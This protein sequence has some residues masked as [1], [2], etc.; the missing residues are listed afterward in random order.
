MSCAKKLLFVLALFFFAASA[1]AQVSP[2][3]TP[4]R[5]SVTAKL[6]QMSGHLI[7]AC[8]VKD[9]SGLAVPS[10]IVSVQKAAAITGPYAIW[11]SKITNVKGQALFP[12]AQP[13]YTWYVRCAATA[14]TAAKQPILSVSQTLTIKGKKPRPSPTATSRP[15]ATATPT[16]RPTVTPS[17]TPRPTVT[18]SPT[19]R[20]TATPTVTLRPTV[21]PTP[22]PRPTATPKPTPP[23]P[24]RSFYVAPGGSNSADG[25]A[26]HPWATIQHAADAVAAG[27]T[28][29][30]AAGQYN[31]TSS[32]TTN[33][34]G[35]ANAPIKFISDTPW[36]SKIYGT[37]VNNYLWFNNGDYN[38]VQGFEITGD[39]N[40]MG[41]IYNYA[42]YCLYQGN[43]VHDILANN[44]GGNGGSGLD[45]GGYTSSYNSYVGNVIGN[46]G[47]KGQAHTVQGIYMAN[48]YGVV[49]NNIVYNVQSYDICLWH[50]A[51]NVTIANNLIWGSGDGGILVGANS[52]TADYSIVTNNISINNPGS[53]IREYGQV[54]THNTYS[55]NV[56][57]GNSSGDYTM[58]VG[59]PQ[60]KITAN[61]QFVNYKADGSGDY[62]LSAGSPCIDSGTSQ[63][64]PTTDYDG[65]PRPQGTGFDVGPYEQ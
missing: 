32:I 40:A 62:H 53:G 52:T 17:P 42:S 12:Y 25:S 50:A 15:T 7:I 41:G 47:V 49:V 4:P 3:P 57:Y 46:I 28:V 29:H 60:N 24:G 1:F 44:P 64:A 5:L 61:A 14:G 31:I 26:Q 63:G 56:T 58:L 43:Y 8:K 34:S 45:S 11:M 33:T 23:D 59:V 18:P 51:T 19:P 21:T 10:Q 54:G 16:P 22:T 48:P 38:I 65:V 55:N 2:T 35:T 36:G 30:V 27:D 6:T 9:S 13:M 37:G 20:P 39:S